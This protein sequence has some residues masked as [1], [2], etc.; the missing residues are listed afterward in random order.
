MLGLSVLRRST[1]KNFIVTVWH[2][3]QVRVRHSSGQQGRPS[4]SDLHQCFEREV[5]LRLSACLLLRMVDL[6]LFVC[7]WLRLPWILP[8]CVCARTLPAHHSTL[9]FQCCP[10]LVLLKSNFFPSGFL[11]IPWSLPPLPLNRTFA[12]GGRQRQWSRSVSSSSRSS[13]NTTGTDASMSELASS[14]ACFSQ[15]TDGSNVGMTDIEE[16][17]LLSAGQ[18]MTGSVS[19]ELSP[20]FQLQLIFAVWEVR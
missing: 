20:V 2:R 13:Q 11:L 5:D 16:N 10:T 12:A 4:P 15:S 19:S 9:C 7:A 8:L 17:V 1:E 6:R 18:G 14:D 3:S